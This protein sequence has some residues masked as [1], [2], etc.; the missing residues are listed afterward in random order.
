[1][2]ATATPRPRFRAGKRG[3]TRKED[4]LLRALY[5]RTRAE[6]LP[7]R[8]GRSHSAIRNRAQT[9]HL[10]KRPEFSLRRPWS[11]R[12]DARLRR[13][14]PHLSTVK[15]AAQLGRSVVAT[16]GRAGKL[17]L[18]KSEKYLASPDAC[19]LRRADNPGIRFRFSKGHVPANKGLRRP[20]YSVGRG[21]MQET[22]FKK[23]QPTKWHPVGSTRLVDGYVYRKISDIRNVTWTRNWKPEH[24]LLW[25]AEHGPLPAK[26]ALAFKNGDRR[27]VRP[28]NLECISRRELMRR[29]SVHNLPAPLVQ[30]I[31][32]LGALK[33]RINRR[34]REEQDRR[35]A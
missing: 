9:L 16:Y 14:Y 27:D 20:G 33:R 11:V 18:S 6:E 3:W 1:M 7:A 5:P 22:Q 17:G 35:S 23:G 15:V 34:S 31:Q 12:D 24:V 21:R 8:I 29:N 10:R 28:D 30:T 4:A 2:S 25:E 26:H 13:L 19:R 32:L